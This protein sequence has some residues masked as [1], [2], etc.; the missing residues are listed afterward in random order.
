MARVR[1]REPAASMSPSESVSDDEEAGDSSGVDV[2]VECQ[3]KRGGRVFFSMAYDAPLDEIPSTGFQPFWHHV[4]PA[5]HVLWHDV[6]LGWSTNQG[7]GSGFGSREW[8]R[9]MAIGVVVLLEKERRRE[10]EEKEGGRSRQQ[11]GQTQRDITDSGKTN[12]AAKRQ[13]H[14]KILQIP[15]VPPYYRIVSSS[16][17]IVPLHSTL[18]WL[19]S[20]SSNAACLFVPTVQVVPK[21]RRAGTQGRWGKRCNQAKLRNRP[22]LQH[23]RIRE[24]SI[25]PPTFPLVGR[26]YDAMRT[27]DPPG[28]AGLPLRI[29]LPCLQPITAPPC[30]PTYPPR[31]RFGF[32][33]LT[34]LV[35]CKHGTWLRTGLNSRILIIYTVPAYWTIR[36]ISSIKRSR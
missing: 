25:D 16:P 17:P 24:A 2:G 18:D 34:E 13:A 15:S 9:E 30:R 3:K 33:A 14:R 23:S 36:E 20:T 8:E 19:E 11:T 7:S 21:G 31:F 22:V 29:P 5:L 35:W 10:K 12:H 6:W 4:R 32:H 26:R 27:L 28:Q 1:G